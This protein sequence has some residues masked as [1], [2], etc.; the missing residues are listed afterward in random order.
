ME[1]NQP[2]KE[3]V[4][5]H[6]LTEK[7]SIELE[8]VEKAMRGDK[9]AFSALFMQTYRSMYLVVRRFLERDEDIYDALQNGYIK[10]YKYLSRLQAPE[11]FVSWLKKTMENAARD[12]RAAVTGPETA[13]EDMAA[14]ADELTAEEPDENSAINEDNVAEEVLDIDDME[15]ED[16]EIALDEMDEVGDGSE[17]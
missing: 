11:A 15:G 10:A 7:P 12:I 8:T 5:A 3:L 6:N 4:S 13:Q 9:E 2:D 17:A 14:F 1:H 16:D